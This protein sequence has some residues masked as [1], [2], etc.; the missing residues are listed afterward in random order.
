M[1]FVVDTNSRGLTLTTSIAGED[2]VYDPFTVPWG[3]IEE[4]DNLEGFEA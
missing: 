3:S 2:G 4:F 1:G